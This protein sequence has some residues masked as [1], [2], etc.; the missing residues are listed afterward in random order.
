MP[1]KQS[2]ADTLKAAILASELPFLTLEQQTGVT[3]QSLM[4]FVK[5][6]R[7]LR[8]DMAD[9]LAVYFGLEL[10]P[11]TS[12]TATKATPKRKGK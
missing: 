6:E 4:S 12:K 2:I 11:T 10:R 3:R 9:K 8:L 5:D 1:T 7:T